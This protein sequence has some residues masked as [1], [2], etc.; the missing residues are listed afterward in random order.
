MS[1]EIPVVDDVGYII[2][3]P[4]YFDGNQE[5]L[6]RDVQR[7]LGNLESLQGKKYK[8]L[9]GL[10]QKAGA[11][12]P[13]EIE[14]GLAEARRIITRS[15]FDS[16][17]R[18][19]NFSWTELRSYGVPKVNYTDIRNKL[20]NEDVNDL[21]FNQFKQDKGVKDIFYVTVDPDTLLTTEHLDR[22]RDIER[23]DDSP[24]VIGGVYG[25]RIPDNTLIKDG[26]RLNWDGFL[27]K[28]DSASDRSLKRAMAEEEF[29]YVKYPYKVLTIEGISSKV[30]QENAL[31]VEKLLKRYPEPALERA[32]LISLHTKYQYLI[33][34]K[35][36][37]PADKAGI[38]EEINFLENELT[39]DKLN[40][41]KTVK[42]SAILY[43]PEPILFINL[44]TTHTDPDTRRE[45]ECD[46]KSMIGR[47]AIWG[48]SP[49]AE[50]QEL[51][52]KT[53]E[54]WRKFQKTDLVEQSFKDRKYVD[55][56]LSYETEIPLRCLTLSEPSARGLPRTLDELKILLSSKKSADRFCQK[57]E[58][59]FYY[60]PQS[61][62]SIHYIQQRESYIDSRFKPATAKLLKE[63]FNTHYKAQKGMLM[64]TLMAQ[65]L[66]QLRNEIA[67]AAPAPAPV[68]A[69]HRVPAAPARQYPPGYD[70]SA[71]PVRG[72]NPRRN[73]ARL[74]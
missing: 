7:I 47:T 12:A 72:G 32:L 27:A 11:V 19:S 43:P 28:F 61:S 14:A 3:I 35:T 52:K 25:L 31:A 34:D 13:R 58:S 68:V 69:G 74:R 16:N 45:V 50:G 42:G 15:S 49:V 2:N 51:V 23:S 38:M 33:G 65:I 41:E 20:F 63:L 70:P 56:G 64:G 55:L 4:L 44:L 66:E 29:T 59:I 46:F 9:I 17:V 37:Q 48:H 26:G 57:L 8:V 10:N 30:L 22:A 21:F 18:V 73:V 71:K 62:L 39:V 40:R 24:L 1:V 60:K 54:I 53:R 5:T 36:L 6:G 67:L